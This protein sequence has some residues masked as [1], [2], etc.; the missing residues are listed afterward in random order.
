MRIRNVGLL[1]PCAAHEDNEDYNTV[2]LGDIAA[3]VV[4]YPLEE[5]SCE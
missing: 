5:D 3:I 2:E 1:H 4:G